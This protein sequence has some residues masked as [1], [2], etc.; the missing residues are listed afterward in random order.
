M[1]G[2]H[3][4]GAQLAAWAMIAFVCA[5]AAGFA[6]SALAGSRAARRM[7]AAAPPAERWR[8]Q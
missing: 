1:F 2:Q 8:R 5:V 6:L 7:A 4:T 3:L